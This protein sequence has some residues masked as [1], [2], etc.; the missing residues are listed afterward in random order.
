M[1]LMINTMGLLWCV[2]NN[3]IDYLI[4]DKQPEWDFVNTTLCPDSRSLLYDIVETSF[5][6]YRWTVT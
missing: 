1:A 5:G 3:D 4:K 2:T 6:I